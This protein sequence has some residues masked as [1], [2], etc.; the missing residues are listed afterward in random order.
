ML[1]NNNR[2]PYAYITK[3]L[4]DLES[5]PSFRW[6]TRNIVN[7]A[8]IK[9]KAKLESEKKKMNNQTQTSSGTIMGMSIE[10]EASTD[11][12]ATLSELSGDVP[13]TVGNTTT[14]SSSNRS[15]GGRPVGTT[16]K[17][18]EERERKIFLTKNLIT[19]NLS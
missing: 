17:A 15:K 3:L 1:L 7:K 16:I 6:L 5:S 14:K 12:T 2:L 9:F 19:K 10:V 11:D 13:S 4:E 18:K 8:F